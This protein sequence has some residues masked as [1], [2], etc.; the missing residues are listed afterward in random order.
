MN[1]ACFYNQN[2]LNKI[3]VKLSVPEYVRYLMGNDIVHI[4]NGESL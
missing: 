2:G 3:N 4:F 1:F